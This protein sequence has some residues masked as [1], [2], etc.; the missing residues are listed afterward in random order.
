ME[1]LQEYCEEKCSR[2]IYKKLAERGGLKDLR[3]K[4]VSIDG[5]DTVVHKAASVMVEFLEN[6]N[7]TQ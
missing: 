4:G 5:L 6:A 3:Y 1:E 7:Q 2:E